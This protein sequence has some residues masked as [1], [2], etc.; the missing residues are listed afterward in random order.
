[1]REIRTEIEIDAPVERVWAVL[2]DFERYGEWNP[3][4]LHAQG[5]PRRGERLAGTIRP[6]RRKSTRFRPTV[7]ECEP[8]RELCWLG[9]LGIPGIF[10]GKHAHRLESLTGGRTRYVQ[11]ER[12]RGVLVPFLGGMLRSTQDGFGEMSEALKSRAQA[13]SS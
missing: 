12:F 1:M 4:I 13:R 6:H 11:S 9:H 5:H 7:V 2:T 8:N 3:F 10:D